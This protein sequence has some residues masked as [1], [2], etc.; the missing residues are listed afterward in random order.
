MSFARRLF[1]VIVLELV[2]VVVRRF[3]LHYFPW[4]SFEAEAIA[5]VLRLITAGVYW[6]LFRPLILSRVPNHAALRNPLLA[7]GLLLLLS[8]PVLMGHYALSAPIAWLFAITSLFVAIKEEFLFR[9]IVQNLL[10]QKLGAWKAICLTSF[11]FTIWHMGVWDLTLWV[12]SQ[13]FVASVL[14]GTI[15]IY[16]GSIVVVVAIHALYDALFSFTPLIPQPLPENWGFLPLVASLLVVS[17]WALSSGRA[18]FGALSGR[19]D[20]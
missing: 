2:Y 13:K 4:S 5:T 19:A 8:I 10:G 20:R 7:V 18:S 14:L 12:F 3:S 1:I 15:Y 6:H 11:V 17:Y 9:G 16:G